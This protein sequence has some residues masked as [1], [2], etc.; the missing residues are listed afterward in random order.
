M[1][2]LFGRR[3]ANWKGERKRVMEVNRTEVPTKNCSKGGGE[4]GNKESN[5]GD[6]FDQS[7]YMHAWKYNN[8]ISI[9][10]IYD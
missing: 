10:L 6:E 8:K 3:G 2:G 1:G 4:R 5:R 9:Q 7:T